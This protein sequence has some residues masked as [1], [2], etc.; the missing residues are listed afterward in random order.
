MKTSCEIV[1]YM[2]WFKEETRCSRNMQSVRSVDWELVLVPTT[3]AGVDDG[4]LIQECDE[5]L[6]WRPWSFRAS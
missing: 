2:G 6:C 5:L 3:M 4:V 1:K